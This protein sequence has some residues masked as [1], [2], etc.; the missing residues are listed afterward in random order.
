MSARQVAG[1]EEQLVVLREQA[2]RHTI[3]LSVA[4]H[5]MTEEEDLLVFIETC[6]AT[7]LACHWPEWALQLLPLLSWEA[8]TAALSFPPASR[9]VYED[10]CRAVLDRLGP[11]PEDY[12]W[13]FQTIRMG[14]GERPFPWARQLEDTAARWL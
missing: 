6:Q 11:S 10:V 14:R 5:Q 2:E 13:Q 7:A 1:Q 9:A 8:Q 3:V 4:L 12:R